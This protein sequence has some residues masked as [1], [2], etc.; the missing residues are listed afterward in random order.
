[1]NKEDDMLSKKILSSLL[2]VM[3]VVT[4]LFMLLIVW[5]KSK[6]ANNEAC[7]WEE[8][9]F[10]LYEDQLQES[11]VLNSAGEFELMRVEFMN[12]DVLNQYRF[13]FYANITNNRLLIHIIDGNETIIGHTYAEASEKEFCT[14]IAKENIRKDMYI[15][16][17]CENCAPGATVTLKESI[18]GSAQRVFYDGTQY[19]ISIDKPLGYELDWYKDC[20]WVVKMWI[21]W[22]AVIMMILIL[23]IVILIGFDR[24]TN[25]ILNIDK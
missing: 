21:G 19:D 3:I 24:F 23:L 15:G 10:Y 17:R 12:G 9:E 1:M 14:A 2:I 16:V 13:C 22:Y 8:N 4:M 11:T 7:G 25:F 18:T 6:I 5:N 20:R